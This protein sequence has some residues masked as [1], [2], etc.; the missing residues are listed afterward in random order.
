MSYAVERTTMRREMC[1]V[2][3]EKVEWGVRIL[4]SAKRKKVSSQ[5][6]T[7]KKRRKNLN[8]AGRFLKKHL[9]FLFK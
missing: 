6:K 9:N 8:F 1:T 3:V 4:G 2:Y 7:H 5:N